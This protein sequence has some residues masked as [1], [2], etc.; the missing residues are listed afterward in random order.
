MTVSALVG[1]AAVERDALDQ[2][3]GAQQL[4]VG[5]GVLG[6]L[7]GIARL[8]G[9]RRCAGGRRRCAR[10]GR[11]GDGLVVLLL[12]RLGGLGLRIGRLVGRLFARLGVGVDDR[13]TQVL[14]AE[15]GTR[16][17]ILD[18]GGLD[19][20]VGLDAFLLDRAARRREVERRGETDGAAAGHL[21]DGLHRALAER[22]GAE[23]DRPLVVLQG[24][25]HDLRSRGR[26]A[27]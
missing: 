27:V 1:A 3:D 10:G 13:A 23:N 6:W 15:A 12:T 5:Y 8:L 7:V 26:A 9:G 17:D 22:A 25:G 20:D 19:L 24:A 2:V 21:H 16:L 11:S 4:V 14:L 18:L